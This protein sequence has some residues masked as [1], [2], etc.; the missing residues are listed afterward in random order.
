MAVTLGGWPAI[1]DSLRRADS[2]RSS[3][4]FRVARGHKLTEFILCSRM[5][6]EKARIRCLGT[7]RARAKLAL[8]CDA[9][10]TSVRYCESGAELQH[11]I[12][13]GSE[14][15]ATLDQ[16]QIEV[17][18]DRADALP[19]PLHDVD[20]GLNRESQES[21]QRPRTTSSEVG[22]EAWDREG[23]TTRSISGE[24]LAIAIMSHSG[25]AEDVV[26]C[27]QST[28]RSAVML[29]NVSDPERE[30]TITVLGSESG[31]LMR[32]LCVA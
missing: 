16:S 32:S 8:G 19:V 7:S 2:N 3:T 27:D 18:S 10:V 12:K 17:E 14:Q 28:P 29:A 26:G 20:S 23:A 1:G 25:A 15:D 5:K 13:P 31:R 30:T 4:I 6:T 24:G 11:M 22:I 9:A 21:L